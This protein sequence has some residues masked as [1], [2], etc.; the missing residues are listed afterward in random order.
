MFVKNGCPLFKM[1]DCV[2]LLFV[3]NVLNFSCHIWFSFLR[4][5][6]LM[7]KLTVLIV[8]NE[9]HK[10]SCIHLASKFSGSLLPG[11]LINL[12]LL[13][14]S[15]HVFVDSFILLFWWHWL[16][17]ELILKRCNFQYFFNNL[18]TSYFDYVRDFVAIVQKDAS[19][20]YTIFSIFAG[21]VGC[22]RAGVAFTVL[23]SLF[24]LIS[25]S[26]MELL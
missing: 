17:S 18:S 12:N 24:A 23:V 21:I 9:V 3:V 2:P 13:K 8:R 16:V 25:S 26:A 1:T 11:F 19:L 5:Q 15:Q 4:P 22:V 14:L 20:A 7:S 6:L 10:S